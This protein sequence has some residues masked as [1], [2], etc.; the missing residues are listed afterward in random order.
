MIDDENEYVYALERA[1]KLD[2]RF[3]AVPNPVE[4]DSWTYIDLETGLPEENPIGSTAEEAFARAYGLEPLTE[5]EERMFEA[6]QKGER[7]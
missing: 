6:K 3:K 7:Q 2:P 5:F 1:A 4:P